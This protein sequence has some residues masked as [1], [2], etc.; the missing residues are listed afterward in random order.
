M[1]SY[2]N[3]WDFHN[4][5]KKLTAYTGEFKVEYYNL[6]E[7]AMGAPIGGECYI[8][9]KENGKY[10]IGDCIAGPP[11]WETNTNR[12]AVPTWTRTL[13]KGTMQ[14]IILTD[15]DKMTLTTFSE[16]FDVLDLSSFDK[17]LIHGY[18]S[19]IYKKRIVAFDIKKA[20]VE[21]VTEL[22]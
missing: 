16:I 5:D 19:P 20:K 6:N 13:L 22:K 9:N 14:K 10:K 18:D 7:I 1:D 8:V 2:P 21:K 17:N 12:V 11:V 4:T 15:L 3:P